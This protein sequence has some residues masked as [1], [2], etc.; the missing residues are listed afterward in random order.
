MKSVN[1]TN[2][3]I[4][5]I[6]LVFLFFSSANAK[7]ELYNF[8]ATTDADTTWTGWTWYPD[9]ANDYGAVG[10][11]KDDGHFYSGG[12]SNWYPRIHEKS[13]YGM[14]T[15]G[16]IDPTDRAPSTSS[17]GSLK[18]Y[19]DGTGSV[20]QASAWYMWGNSF[21]ERSMADSGTDRL[22]YY[23]KVG[24]ADAV[25]LS[26]GKISNANMHFGTYLCWDGGAD[27]GEGC[28]YEASNQ[29]YYHYITLP[30]G[31]MPWVH[32]QL[33]QHPTHQRGRDEP[34][35]P[36]NDPV[37][38]SNGQH[39]FESMNSFYLEIRYA[40]SNPTT[41][42]IDEVNLWNQLQEENEVS[43]GS[44]VW[45][46]YWTSTNKWQIGFGSV[47]PGRPMMATFE[48]R[49]STSPI[50]NANYASATIAEPEYRERGT[51]NTFTL[52]DSG[53]SKQAWTQFEIPQATADSADK[54]YFAIR[55]VSA[56]VNGDGYNS[57]T[58][59]I[60]TIDYALS[61]SSTTPSTVMPPGNLLL[62]SS[63]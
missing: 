27:G 11:R 20:N 17:G 7:T 38:I 32:M 43:I 45:V 3:V 50:T 28:P 36:D 41:Y 52:S 35:E 9:G 54:I 12:T 15:L 1:R 58:T 24:G 33:D 2:L 19:D 55:D 13:D 8:D 60:K 25:D 30:F 34:N 37:F 63:N 53:W 5:T 22:S 62:N 21:G 29:H 4:C 57:P 49:W 44:A 59:N 51:S 23:L 48:V 18:L 16:A 10:W 39:Y 61:A 56:T 14:S 31:D 40:Q 47:W 46:G 42:W 26:S 6:I